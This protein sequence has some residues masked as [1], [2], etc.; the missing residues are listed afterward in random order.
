VTGTVILND[1]SGPGPDEESTQ[2][3]IEANTIGGSL[4]CTG[5]TPPPTNDGHPNK[6][7]G[8]ASGQCTGF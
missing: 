7:I 4:S 5:N 6:I 3:E 8:S 2:S 1:S